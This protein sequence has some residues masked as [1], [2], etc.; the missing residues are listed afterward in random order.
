MDP[1][2]AAPVY[3]SPSEDALRFAIPPATAY[4]IKKVRLDRGR[5]RRSE[6]RRSP[7]FWQGETCRSV[8][9]PQQQKDRAHRC[10]QR[11]LPRKPPGEMFAPARAPKSPQ[12]FQALEARFAASPSASSAASFAP[13]WAASRAKPLI[14]LLQRFADFRCLK[15]P[16]QP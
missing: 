6:K 1:S 5:N 16:Q 2:A 3:W 7:R 13:S 10:T 9:S 14:G 8:T 12:N 11:S 15:M 4:D